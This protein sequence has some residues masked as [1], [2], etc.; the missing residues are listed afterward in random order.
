MLFRIIVYQITIEPPNQLG[1]I[2]AWS[3]ESQLR[4]FVI[5]INGVA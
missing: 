4:L 1:V 5:Q 3:P 2:D